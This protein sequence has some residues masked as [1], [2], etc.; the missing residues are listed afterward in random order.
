[1][2]AAVEIAGKL[3]AARR[4]MIL[5]LPDNG[6]WGSVPS[7]SVAKRAWWNMVPGL[8]DHKHCP[9]DA[10]EWALNPLGLAVRSILEGE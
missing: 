4:L 3:T 9:D 6:D 2:S 7:R 8:I 10:N 5:A 1:M